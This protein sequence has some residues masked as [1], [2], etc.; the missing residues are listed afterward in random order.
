V[1]SNGFGDSS[2]TAV[3]S[4]VSFNGMIYAG[5]RNWDTGAEV[6]KSSDGLSWTQVV[7]GGFG[8]GSATGWVDSLSAYNGRLLAVLRNYNDGA[9]V[10]ASLDGSTW[11]QLNSDGW[12]DNNNPYTGDGDASI[13]VF[14][15]HLV[16]GTSN[17]ASG[18]EIW[19]FLGTQ[20]YLP[21]VYK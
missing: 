11:R 14:D 15:N 8:G 19:T 13:I 2:N 16:F 5:T 1:N 10:M 21:S 7:S 17:T 6:W 9:K 4:L 20:A 18:A 12:G 3:T